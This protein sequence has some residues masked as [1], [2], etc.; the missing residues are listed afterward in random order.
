MAYGRRKKGGQTLMDMA[1]AGGKRRR[2]AKAKRVGGK[3][4]VTPTPRRK[5]PAQAREFG[6]RIPVGS[7][8]PATKAQTP[9]RKIPA[10]ARSFRGAAPKKAGVAPRTTRTGAQR[11][12]DKKMWQAKQKEARKES[13]GMKYGSEYKGP[14]KISKK[15]QDDMARSMELGSGGGL[16]KAGIAAG[17]AAA[18]LKG[19]KMYKAK[20]A[21][22]LASGKTGG[23][24]A[25]IGATRA[26]SAASRT[27]GR[28][29]VSKTK[30]P[31]K[32]PPK[33]L[34]DLLK[35][36][37]GIGKPKSAFTKTPKK[38]TQ[39]RYPK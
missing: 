10:G 26:G 7:I 12:A 13:A 2:A 18:G 11:A 16:I 37:V 23:V 19:H 36:V 8:S 31:K 27:G 39:R 33:F 17:L 24:M 22:D 20:K 4:Y 35:R 25:G 6:A 38:R 34:S 14:P 28:A 15:Q 9:K 30:K 21:A 29:K 32:Q 3:E 5:S 1:R